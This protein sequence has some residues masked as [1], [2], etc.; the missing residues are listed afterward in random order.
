MIN[1]QYYSK[2]R[3]LIHYFASYPIHLSFTTRMQGCQLCYHLDVEHWKLC[4]NE[5]RKTK[6]EYP[7][8]MLQKSSKMSDEKF[9]RCALY[10]FN[11]KKILHIFALIGELMYAF[12]AE[13]EFAFGLSEATSIVGPVAIEVNGAIQSPLNHGPAYSAA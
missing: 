4:C 5:A 6:K 2:S 1:T 8:K 10:E 9:E 3:C 7:T 13:P 12:V 11:N